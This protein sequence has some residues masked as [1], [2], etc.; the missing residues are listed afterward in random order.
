[1]LLCFNH[2]L[3]EAGG[4]VSLNHTL[5]TLP[6]AVNLS[7]LL[8]QHLVSRCVCYMKTGTDAAEHRLLSLPEPHTDQLQVQGSLW[9]IG[10]SLHDACPSKIRD[11]KEQSTVLHAMCSLQPQAPLYHPCMSVLWRST[12]H[13][14]LSGCYRRAALDVVLLLQLT[15]LTGCL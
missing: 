7:K 11:L 15:Q 5:K 3:L 4:S 2:Q 8:L 12:T 14:L 6:K 9:V 10:Q 13:L 1:M